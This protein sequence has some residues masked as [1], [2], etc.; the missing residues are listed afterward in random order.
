MRLLV[1]I[2]FAA[3]CGSSPPAGDGDATAPDARTHDGPE[4]G[5]PG[6]H[7]EGNHLVTGDGA[8]WHGRGANLHD[9]RS[10]DAC[11]AFAPSVGEV[12]R[13]IDALV[14][15]W[16]GNFIRLDLESYT[17]DDGFRVHW[18]GPT[19]D[20]DYLADI[21]A[22]VDHIG[23]KPGVYVL[24]SLWIDPSF[25]EEGWPSAGTREVWRELATT[26]ADTP[27]VMFGL[28]NEPEYNFDGS[29]DAAV[30]IAM[31]EAV[32]AIREAE[33]AAGG[34]RHVVAV[35]GTGAWSRRL[36]YYV[37]HPITAGGGAD[38]AYEIHIYDPASELDAMLVGPAA[39]LP[40]IIG[41][42]GPSNMTLDDTAAL[43]ELAEELEVPYLAW[44]FHMR[45]P[46]N[47]LVDHSGG[48]CGV[49]MELEP[50]AWGQ[51]LKDRLARPY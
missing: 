20:A 50:T 12:T 10:C 32:A 41:E 14:D 1:P 48:A 33:E 3:A 39:T 29:E 31:N 8:I 25:T 4:P 6:L 45:C 44:T 16:G 47:L 22:I 38:V 11:T 18:G 15:D 24:L 40:V 43:M 42:F 26:F 7:V 30:W 27:H 37:D 23:T 13:R 5:A 46:P 49:D 17:G 51:Q 9:T 28:V 36:D 34:L 2:L 19:E 35:Q 21:V